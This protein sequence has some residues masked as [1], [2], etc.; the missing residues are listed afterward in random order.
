ADAGHRVRFEREEKRF[1]EYIAYLPSA[2]PAFA[3]PQ[4]RRALGMAIDV[5]GIIRA[6]GMEEF[7]TPAAG[8][9]PP[10]FRDLYD[11]ARTKP[12]PFDTVAAKRILDARG[13]RDRDGD[14]VRDRDGRPLRFTLLTN[15]G[16]ARRNDV[17]QIVQ[18]QW[19]RIGVD[20]RLRQL[21][22]VTFL[23]T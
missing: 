6:L 18:Q 19:K 23:N 17:T 22:T 10:I 7:T 14:G 21:E 12:L 8:P 11:T 16:N 5:P 4:V 20:A 9:Y 2:H 15:A 3:D 13:W 1:W